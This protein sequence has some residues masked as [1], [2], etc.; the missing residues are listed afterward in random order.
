MKWL[1][2]IGWCGYASGCLAC[3]ALA[4]LQPVGQG[5]LSIWGFK[6]Y[7]ATT[8]SCSGA[9]LDAQQALP[10]PFALEIQYARA[11]DREQLLAR[12]QAEWRR[13]AFADEQQQAWLSQVSGL[14]P[15]V[16][17]GDTLTLWY[18]ADGSA[19][20]YFNRQLLGRV[21]DPDFAP[22]FVAIWLHPDAR[23]PALRARLL[24]RGDTGN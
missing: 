23:E 24:G 18:Q 11:I 7:T 8:L 22:A 14:W 17:A 6:V 5:Q 16:G 21:N 10:K 3:E 4:D 15:S 20:F 12:T 9:P 1:V 19:A 13:L 2:L